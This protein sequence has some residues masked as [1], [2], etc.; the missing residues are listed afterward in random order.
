VRLFNRTWLLA[1]LLTAAAA[2]VPA[3]ALAVVPP[4]ATTPTL[5]QVAI[6]TN[7]GDQTESHVSGDWA[8]YTDDPNIR[9]YNFSTGTHGVI[10]L[11][12]VATR[13][14]LSEVSGS[15]IVF[16][17]RISGTQVIMVFDAATGAPPVE[18]GTP[19]AVG[20]RLSASI[21]GNTVAFIDQGLDSHGELMIYDLLT[22]VTQRITS[23]T[24]YDQNTSVSP[25]GN[26]VTWEHCPTHPLVCDIWQAVKS[27]ATWTVSAVTSVASPEFDSDTN[28]T[29]VVYGSQR[30]PEADIFWRSVAGGAEN[31]LEMPGLQS[32]PSI[33]GNLITFES[34]PTVTDRTDIFVYDLLSNRLYQVTNTPE[35][36]DEELADITVL[37]DGRA[38]VIWASD[39]EGLG[40]HNIRAATFPVAGDPAAQ[41]GD[42][43]TKTIDYLNLPVLSAPLRLQLQAAI[44]QAVAGNRTAVCSALQW[45]IVVVRA[46]PTSA[47]TAAHKAELIADATRIRALLGC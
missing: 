16:S 29:L 14:L 5:T 23:D 8:A 10:P 2:I 19:I 7:V 47:I 33:A 42:L 39:E 45:Y 46:L 37:P 36:V 22:G 26:V 6:N 9:Y 15:K 20:T 24:E 12:L 41:I 30:G 31:Q 38:R 35:P 21:G 18:I 25:D 1:L 34:R 17:R 40:I 3:A 11:G 43:I 44:N 27:G 4:A 28:G 32:R 13:D